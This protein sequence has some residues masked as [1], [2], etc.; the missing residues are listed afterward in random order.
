MEN[1][2]GK[3]ILR[4]TG[5]RLGINKLNELTRLV[6]EIS[7]REGVTPEGILEAPELKEVISHTRGS[8][9]EKFSRIKKYLISRRFPNASFQ[10]D[11]SVQFQRLGGANRKSRVYREPFYPEMIYIEESV[12]DSALAKRALKLYGDA[13]S[14]TIKSL[15][16][17]H[18][19]NRVSGIDL[20]KREIFIAR[21]KWDFIKPCPC[22]KKVVCCSYHIV[23]LGFGCPYDCSYCYLQHYTNFPGIVID[24]NVDDFLEKIDAYLQNFKNREIR[25][26]T[27]EF[28]DSL[29][30]DD[31]TE[32]SKTLVPFFADKKALL[33]LKTK[34]A[35]VENLLKLDHGGRT[36]VAWTLSPEEVAAAEEPGA[37]PLGERFAA[38]EKCRDAGYKV[39]FH[40]DPIIFYGG[41]DRDYQEVVNRV[42]DSF[43]EIAWI[44]LGTL[45][46]H[47]TLKPIIEERFPNSDYLYAEMVTGNDG[48]MRYYSQL[49]I[50]IFTKMRGWIRARSKTTPLYLCMEEKDIWEKVMGVEKPWWM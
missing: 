49:R 26:G 19:E 4:Q 40:F 9:L 30:L 16:D 25:V 31:M 1:E 3:L 34:S 28:G 44:S 21:Q 10:D 13:P 43:K 35:N 41:W 38:A 36:V 2:L 20:K 18:R 11:F 23:N 45:R 47:R 50:D 46:F 32:Y 39:A 5:L 14:K 33:E 48:K 7:R 27:G 37:A 15:K 24:A 6:Y 42:F 29:A 8:Y 12:R 22:T 17:F